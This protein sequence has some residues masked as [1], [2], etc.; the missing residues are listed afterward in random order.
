MKSIQLRP[1]L[2]HDQTMVSTRSRPSVPAAKAGASKPAARRGAKKRTPLSP[3]VK[4]QPPKQATRSKRGAKQA[5]KAAPRRPAPKSAKATG[6]AAGKRQAAKPKAAPVAPAAKRSG[7]GGQGG[8][9]RGRAASAVPLGIVDPNAG[10]AGGSVL[11]KGGTVFDVMLVQR[12]AGRQLDEFCILQV[13]EAPGG[14]FFFQRGGQTGTTGIWLKLQFKNDT[15]ALAEF[16]KEFKK[17]TGRAWG[18]K[19][20]SQPIGGKYEWLVRDHAARAKTQKSAPAKWQ[21]YVN[22][23]VDGKATGWYDYTDDGSGIVE[24]LFH[25][26]GSNPH[27]QQRFVKSGNWLYEVNLDQMTQRNSQHANH[28]VRPIRRKAADGSII[29]TASVTTAKAKTKKLNTKGAPKGNTAKKGSIGQGKVD[30]ACVVSGS[31]VDDYDIMLNQTNIGFNNNKFYVIQLIKA[32]FGNSYYLFTRWGR[33]GEPGQTQLKNFGNLLPPA[34][35]AFEAKFKA[36]TC[37][38]WANR[39]KFVPH[40]G[41]YEIVEMGHDD[42]QAVGMSIGGLPNNVEPCKLDSNTQELMEFIFS[43]DMFTS[44]MKNMEVDVAKMPLGQ[45]SQAQVQ[46]GYDALTKLRQAI[47]AGQTSNLAHLT[48]QFYQ[49]IPH[50]FGRRRP[51]VINTIAMVQEKIE[52][53]DVLG[54]ITTAQSLMKSKAAKAAQRTRHPADEHYDKLQTDLE[55][56]DSTE[57]DFKLIQKYMQATM[58]QRF[59]LGTLWRVDRHG[60]GQR[61]DAHKGI[62]NRKL[63][64]HGTNVAVVAAILK[65]GLRIMPHSGGRVGKGIYLASENAKSAQYVRAAPLKGKNTGIMF[66]AEAALG[67][68]HHIVK[69]DWTLT[70]PPSGYDCI[71][72]KGRREPDPSKD[73]SMLLDGKKVSVPQ[74]APVNMGAY[75]NSSFFNS[76]YLLYKESQQRLRYMMTVKS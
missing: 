19:S 4:A 72:A 25:E 8:V 49:V 15:Q 40:A 35:A 14:Y 3:P 31:I 37:N 54:D 10:V 46:R 16:K 5:A 56:V 42:N 59:A 17:R 23:G 48:S 38:N 69:D 62:G 47:N 7:H 74:G 44:A 64:W 29:E 6:R 20:A 26:W 73:T 75:A 53:C 71:I 21:Y 55:V 43:N 57:A 50:S 30:S 34:E 24:E 18:S 65:G 41:K 9:K 22:D 27:M 45:L 36:K 39:S 11:N 2:A 66:L 12:D 51:P 70:K 58:G 60:E 63:L 76:E 33:V 1:F 61:F 67:K 52:L 28:K 32:T 13:I 68:E